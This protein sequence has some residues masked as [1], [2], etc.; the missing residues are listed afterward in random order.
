MRCL[1]SAFCTKIA[2]D[3][4]IRSKAAGQAELEDA[5]RGPAC[6]HCGTECRPRTAG[7]KRRA[8]SP[9]PNTP[10]PAKRARGDAAERPR[11]SAPPTGTSRVSC[12]LQ[13][14]DKSPAKKTRSARG[15]LPPPRLSIVESFCVVGSVE[16]YRWFRFRPLQAVLAS[17]GAAY[18]GSES[19]QP[20]ADAVVMVDAH[21][22]AA[23]GELS[24]RERQMKLRKAMAALMEGTVRHRASAWGQL[25]LGGTVCM[26]MSCLHCYSLWLRHS[27]ARDAACA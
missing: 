7:G 12:T 15:S 20:S 18:E 22:F 9:A 14:Q 5:V 24:A 23:D 3:A 19:W 11:P 13:T 6:K 26:A 25:L 1:L 16:R 2:E 27:C 4:G 8:S 10:P 17:M 21:W